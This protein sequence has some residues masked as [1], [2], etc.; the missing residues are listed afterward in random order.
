MTSS[1]LALR[2]WFL[3][4]LCLGIGCFLYG[5]LFENPAISVVPLFLIPIAALI[6]S[7]PAYIILVAGV[8][9]IQKYFKTVQHKFI[10]LLALTFFI[11]LGYGLCVGL[12][13]NLF[14]SGENPWNDFFENTFLLT[15]ILFACSASA[16][17]LKL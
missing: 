10:A 14:N 8:A 1:S 12:I 7:I 17:A 13:G 11:T 15:A 16:V 2:L 9:L 6:V 3:T 5:L 4:S